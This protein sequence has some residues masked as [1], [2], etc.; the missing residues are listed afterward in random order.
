M[1]VLGV[2]QVIVVACQAQLRRE[3]EPM[4]AVAGVRVLDIADV[5]EV[6]ERADRGDAGVVLCCAEEGCTSLRMLSER[7]VHRRPTCP[8]ALVALLP[9]GTGEAEV[10]V[11]QGLAY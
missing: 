3:L 11:V 10:A 4:L 2:A 9:A 6:I 5:D 8:W 7:R 1:I